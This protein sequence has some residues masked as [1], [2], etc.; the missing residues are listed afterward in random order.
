MF[1][2]RLALSHQPL[3]RTAY[4][5]LAGQIQTVPRLSK[6]FYS[7]VDHPMAWAAYYYYLVAV[8]VIRFGLYMLTQVP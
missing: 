1:Q 7:F 6:F 3:T 5:L 4:G 2:R 8:G